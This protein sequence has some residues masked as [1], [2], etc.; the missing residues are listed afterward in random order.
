MACGSTVVIASTKFRLVPA[1]TVGVALDVR[2]ALAG[3]PERAGRHVLRDRRVRRREGVVAE[4]H[5]RDERRVDARVHAIADRRA[6][7]VDAVVVG[8]DRRGAEVRVLADVGV[9]DVGEVR[10]LPAARRRRSS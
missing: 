8:G 2:L 9:A 10:D 4:R 7:L 5:R 3:D 1:L 6:V